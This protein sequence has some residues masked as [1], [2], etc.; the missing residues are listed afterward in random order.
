MKYRP[1]SALSIALCLTIGCSRGPVAPVPAETIAPKPSPV[2][3]VA[4][5]APVKDIAKP[6]DNPEVIRTKEPGVI[7]GI[8]QGEDAGH[9]VVWLKPLG[10]TTL[11]APPVETVHLRLEGGKY[12][13]HLLLAQKGSS[14]ELRTVEDRA[15]FQASGAATFSA[16]VQRGTMQTFPLATAGTIEVR[17]QLHPE[18][19]PAY[20]R[21]LDGVPG[22]ATGSEGRFQLPPVSAGEYELTLWHEKRLSARVR[23][24]LDANE[25]ADVRWTVPKS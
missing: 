3:S 14:L 5:P 8:F 9:G 19:T 18:R 21:V 23:L 11:P 25:G 4:Q 20:I 15:D 2:V 24:K 16:T 1:G 22:A 13:P 7:R 17:S 12:R 10:K 6:R